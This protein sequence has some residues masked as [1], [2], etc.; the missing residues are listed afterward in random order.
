MMGP[1]S[2]ARDDGGMATGMRTTG[3]RDREED[4]DNEGDGTMPTTDD[5]APTPIA[6]SDCLQ[7]GQ[8]VLRMTMTTRRKP[9]CEGQQ[10]RKTVG[11]ERMRA[12][13]GQQL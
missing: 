12:N 10:R 8:W 3:T 4:Q 7:G 13:K 9:D 1:G 11:T 6:A 2:K 5:P